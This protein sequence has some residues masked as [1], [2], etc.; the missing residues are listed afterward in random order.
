MIIGHNRLRNLRAGVEHPSV[1]KRRK[2][3]LGELIDELRPIR[4][5]FGHLMGKYCV[6]TVV[7]PDKMYR[8]GEGSLNA[9]LGEPIDVMGRLVGKDTVGIWFEPAKAVAEPDKDGRVIPYHILVRWD[10]I[11]TATTNPLMNDLHYDSP[12]WRGLK[13]R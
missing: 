3:N 11:V 4:T 12:G 10:Y 9:V 8:Y 6:L 13:P 2:H 5:D 1:S 7:G